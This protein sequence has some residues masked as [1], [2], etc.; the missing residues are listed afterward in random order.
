MENQFVFKAHPSTIGALMSNGKGTVFTQKDAEQLTEYEQRKKGTF[1]S[2]SGKPLAITD[3][4]EKKRVD[5]I[6][7]RDKKPELGDTAKSIV[8]AQLLYDVFGI[9]NDF[10]SK[11]T[12]KGNK[13]EQS[14]IYLLQ[15]VAGLFGIEKNETTFENEYL[16]GTPDVIGPDNV[17]DVKTPWSSKTFPWFKKTLPTNSYEWQLQGY[18]MLTTKKVGYIA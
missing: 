12:D 15:K 18:F 9:P 13:C 2:K 10:S 6:A 4:M 7:K 5:L 16:I 8:E 11:Q 1:L 14:S 17:I 3:E